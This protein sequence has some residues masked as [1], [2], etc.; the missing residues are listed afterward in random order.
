MGLEKP[1]GPDFESDI[2]YIYYNTH[3]RIFSKDY[4]AYGI[5]INHFLTFPTEEM[6]DAFYENFKEEI[7]TCKELL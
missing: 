6:R 7:E 1:W 5:T 2:Y 4:C 3:K